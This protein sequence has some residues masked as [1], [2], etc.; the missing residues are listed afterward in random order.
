MIEALEQQ[1]RSFIVERFLYGR[2]DVRLPS[3]ASLVDESVIDS[4]GV[5]ELVAFIEQ[6]YGIEVGDSEVIPDNLGSVARIARFVQN[7]SG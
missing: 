2:S 5:L 4:T 6:K 7:K 3:D 1:I